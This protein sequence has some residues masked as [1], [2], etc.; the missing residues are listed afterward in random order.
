M[1]KKA[2]RT[3]PF[4]FQFASAFWTA[5]IPFIT[6]SS[7]AVLQTNQGWSVSFNVAV[8]PCALMGVLFSARWC[9]GN[10]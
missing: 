3:S 2:T 8:V 9:S 10:C 7:L 4:H 1:Q 5:S 6:D